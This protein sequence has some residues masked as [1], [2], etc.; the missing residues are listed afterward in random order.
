[1]N[2]KNFTKTQLSIFI[3]SN[4]LFVS[5]FL[6]MFSISVHAESIGNLPYVVDIENWA[7]YDGYS[8]SDLQEFYNNRW[9]TYYPCDFSVDG[10]VIKEY[11]ETITYLG[12]PTVFYFTNVLVP[13]DNTSY[14]YF[15][16]WSDIYSQFDY[17]SD[18]C[19]MSFY[20]YESITFAT[21]RNQYN[22]PSLNALGGRFSTGIFYN[23]FYPT[24]VKGDFYNNTFISNTFLKGDNLVLCNP[25]PSFVLSGH[26]TEPTNNPNNF[27][28]GNNN[29]PI[30]KPTFPTINYYTY[31]TYNPPSLDSTNVESLLESI[32]DL[33]Q[34]NFEYQITNFV[35]QFNN[36]ID[37]ISNLVD[38]IVLSFENGFN[39]VILSIQDLMT[40]LYN[41]FVSL[42]QPI[43]DGLIYITMPIDSDV[44]VSSIIN[45]NFYNGFE[46]TKQF[47]NDVDNIFDIT[48]PDSFIIEI[49]LENLDFFDT[50]FLDFNLSTVYLNLG[51]NVLPFRNALRVFLWCMVSVGTVF[52][53]Q[54][55]LP[56]ML[57]GDESGGNSNGK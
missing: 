45:T 22:D 51:S 8:L 2:I 12:Q 30:T 31:T 3:L 37:N 53:I 49:H 5:A 17:N 41:N 27:I 10:V 18:Y 47:F 6:L 24:Y 23:N 57:K 28:N 1:M 38:Y 52:Y 36:L 34:Y 50:G 26:A 40:D 33:I 19:T 44:I 9:G 48:E 11:T 15:E 35:G 21:Y 20:N 54:K 4:V 25:K 7:N 56:S 29:Q 16:N 43:L 32:Y 13:I 42:F 14:Y 55:N 39:K 46:D